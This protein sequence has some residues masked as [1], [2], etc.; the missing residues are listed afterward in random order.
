MKTHHSTIAACLAVAQ[1]VWGTG[2]ATMFHG[3][4]QQLPIDVKPP[5]TEVTLYRWDGEVVAGP[6]TSPITQ[7][8]HRPKWNQPYLAV[9]SKDG[10]CPQY[11]IPTTSLTAG[12]TVDVVWML[13]TMSLASVVTS[14]IDNSNGSSFQLDEAPFHNVS[15]QEEPCGG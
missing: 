9:A 2:C 11:W 10:H 4:H 6:L 14:L 7:K 12:G 13:V 5:G 15:L 1:L 8:V 3:T